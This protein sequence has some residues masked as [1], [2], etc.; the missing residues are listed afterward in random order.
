[1]NSEVKAF[2]DVVNIDVN[3]LK[4]TNAKINK[5]KSNNEILN[6]DC[7]QFKDSIDK[8][9]RLAHEIQI[10]V[11]NNLNIIFYHVEES[12]DEANRLK[13]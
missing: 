10:R 2:K 3:N 7:D 1:M 13:I 12:S 5:L 8:M 11:E 6:S 4:C 9:P